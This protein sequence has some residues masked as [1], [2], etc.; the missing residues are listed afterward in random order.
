[1]PLV[2]PARTLRVL[3]R[4]LAI[5]GYNASGARP[6]ATPIPAKLDTKLRAARLYETDAYSWALEQA[7]ALRARNHAT[8]DWLNVAEEIEQLA[9]QD[10]RS[11]EGFCAQAVH[12]LLKME[13]DYPERPEVLAVWRK[14]VM[15]F[16]REMARLSRESRGMRGKY[17]QMLEKAY[18]DGRKEAVESLALFYF[19]QTESSS[20]SA[21]ARR[22]LAALPVD[23]PYDVLHVAGLDCRRAN[24]AQD[25]I[26][27]ANVARTLNER[28]DTNY[29]I[30]R[31]AVR[32]WGNPIR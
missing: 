29:D 5:T 16:R 1:M 4:C 2:L 22:W 12:H 9:R 10:E 3:R 13:H 27:P 17:E 8:I 30:L 7:Q 26:W 20:I 23:C 32:R 31:P 15:T 18:R 28:L 21:L 6:M 14:E 11:W 19:Q 24:E 25:D